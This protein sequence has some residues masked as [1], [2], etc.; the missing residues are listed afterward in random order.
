LN[1][2]KRKDC[3]RKGS[4]PSDYPGAVASD[5]PDVL[6]V[7]QEWVK[8]VR[9]RLPDKRLRERWWEFERARAALYRKASLL[10]ALFVMSSKAT[11]HHAIAMVK[12][13]MVFSQNLHVF[14]SE[15][16]SFYTAIA[17]RAHEIWSRYFGTTF[18]DDLTYVLEDCFETFP[19]PNNLEGSAVLEIAGREYCG[20]RAEVM[21]ARNEGMTKTYNR[22]HDR[23]ETAADIERLRQLHAE[24]DRAVLESYGWHELAAQA[25]AVFL[26]ATN[27]D[28]HTYQGRLFWPSEFRDEV[29]ARLLALNAERNAEEVRLGIALG[30][31]GKAEE[32]LD[33]EIDD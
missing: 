7:V 6:K 24:M 1:T 23:R 15:S 28:D 18:K 33:E 4:V 3:L 16:L 27:E 26:D 31:K 32:D 21:V 20:H 14:T 17:C 29:L 10:S 19:F 8:P 9:E 11:P 13:G 2:E 30:T 22:F 5:W 25:Q 12:S